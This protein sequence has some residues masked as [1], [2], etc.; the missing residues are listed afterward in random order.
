VHVKFIKQTRR[1]SSTKAGEKII[2]TRDVPK[3]WQSFGAFQL[4]CDSLAEDAPLPP[5]FRR[6]PAAEIASIL[7]NA[8]HRIPNTCSSPPPASGL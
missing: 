2:M 5:S 8:F 7:F 1:H 4:H 6:L 3:R